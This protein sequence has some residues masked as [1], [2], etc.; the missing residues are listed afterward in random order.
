M[1]LPSVE[2]L[3]YSHGEAG[4]NAIAALEMPGVL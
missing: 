4:V 2:T 3:G 1:I